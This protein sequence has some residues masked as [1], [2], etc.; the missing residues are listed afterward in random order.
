MLLAC[1]ALRY[2]NTQF[3]SEKRWPEKYKNGRKHVFLTFSE[4]KSKIPCRIA[5]PLYCAHPLSICTL[6]LLQHLLIQFVVKV[7]EKNWH[8]SAP[9][10]SSLQDFRLAAARILRTGITSGGGPCP[11]AMNLPGRFSSRKLAPQENFH[12]TSIPPC[13]RK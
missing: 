6:N 2:L 1:A 12:G 4:Y 10:L 3:S 8:R 11:G 13:I 7:G 9:S 5:L